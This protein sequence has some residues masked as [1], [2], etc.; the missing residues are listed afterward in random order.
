[1]KLLLIIYSLLTT[2]IFLI[3]GSEA[4]AQVYAERSLYRDTYSSTGIKTLDVINKYGNIKVSN[5]NKDSICISTETYL[6]SSTQKKLT[7]LKSIVRI[8]YKKEG[9]VITAQTLFGDNKAAFIKEIQ[10]FTRDIT[11]GMDKKIEINYEVFL[12]EN[13]RLEIYNQYGDVVLNDI[14]N[15]LKVILS[16]GSFKTG[17]IKKDINLKFKFVNAMMTDVE[18]GFIELKYSNININNAKEINLESKSSEIYADNI[19]ILK[20]TSSRDKID[21]GNL[22]YIYGTSGY[23]TIR[24]SKLNREM[25]CYFSYGQISISNMDKEISL[26]DIDS[27]R[28]DIK[29][30]IPK[31]IIYSY[32]ILYH[33]NTE[34][35]LPS[36]EKSEVSKGMD[37]M[38]VIK[39]KTGNNPSLR[40]QI[41][42]LKKCVIQIHETGEQIN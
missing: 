5:W 24:V 17:D 31:Q 8:N 26:I 37:E 16:N 39:G 12:P 27:E 35:L 15:E 32:D 2:T 20:I 38:K 29:L 11:P 41:N 21:I 6:S 9:S 23:S 4:S 1:M 40:L 7:K 14:N 18:N 3:P 42:A 28:T 19:D 13:I 30:F 25:D 10:E 33:E 34:I 22:N 36:K